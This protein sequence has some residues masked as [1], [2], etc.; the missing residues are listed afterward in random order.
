MR[1]LRLRVRNYRG[2]ADREIV[3]A[4]SGVTV[5]AGPNEIGKSSLAEAIDL[6]FDELDT[7][8]RQSVRDVKPADRDA[9]TEIEIDV[10]TGPYAFTYSKRFHRRHAT[11]LR[12]TRPR[13]EAWTGRDAHRR[14]REILDETIDT[15][16]WRA[17]RVQQGEGLAQ[18][19]WLGHGALAAALDRAAGGA[20]GAHAQTLFEAAEA[21]CARYF[22]RSGRERQELSTALREAARA[23]HAEHEA[24]E[25]LARL[26][27]DTSRAAEL[28]S[29]RARLEQADLA[30]ERALREAERAFEPIGTLREAAA[31]AA[32]RRDAAAADVRYALQALRQRSQ[33]VTAHAAS[34]ADLALLAGEI[35]SGEPALAGARAELDH[36]EGV[37]ARAREAFEAEA[38]T[39]ARLRAAAARQRAREEIDAL[40]QQRARLAAEREAVIAAEREVA[41]HR[42]DEAAVAEIREAERAVL[43][44]QARVES[45]GP[46]VRLSAHAELTGSLDGGRLALAEGESVEQRVAE[47]LLVSVPGL[48]DL[49]VVAGAGAAGRVKALDEARTRWRDRCAVCDVADHADA[50]RALSARR[51]AERRLAERRARVDELARGGSEADLTARIR[52]A[53]ATARASEAAASDDAEAP[54][55]ARHTGARLA[56]AD[57]RVRS[58][59]D[60]CAGAERR[61]DALLD[62]H[63]RLADHHRETLVRHELAD[64]AFR[65]L[66]ARLATA[67]AERADAELARQHELAA[68]RARSLE[69]RAA[70]ADRRLAEA[71]PA[72]AEAGLARARAA[73]ERSARDSSR[74]REELA[75]LSARLELRGESGL[76]QRV[77]EAG[78][79]ADARES[80][81]AGLARRARAARL[82]FDTLREEREIAREGYALPLATR[83][84]EF[85]RPV[86]GAGFAVEL[87]DSLRIARRIQDGLSLPFD[88]LSA[89]A[90]EQLALIS[91]LAVA[92]LVADAGGA[93]VILDDALGHSDP[94]RLA[95]LGRALSEA[96]ERVQILVLTCTPERFRDVAG[97]HVVALA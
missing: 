7:T 24:R 62:R 49:T 85:G 14:A 84:Q 41:L 63:R 55:A 72:Q 46:L 32:A 31:A 45:E 88:Q 82:L 87:D 4:P 93:P 70:E 67:R 19:S 11:A 9:D 81:A 22:T 8:T 42:I 97:A 27:D 25:E 2:I 92:S 40:A 96:G 73:R 76:Y 65:D 80:E 66:E 57:A 50:L 86:F 39:E 54:D 29:A 58:A 90:R 77:E 5:I 21:E 59:R 51:D 3:P 6:L 79:E 35:E 26:A 89:G 74:L 60:A 37:L 53:E 10:E 43:R 28:R 69:A 17:L 44:A 47:S 15:G 1:I 33:L 16:L 68:E 64:H 36:A 12:V 38:G 20:E 78:A 18:A 91:R 13:V 56:D 83:I 23:R 30:C 95:R 75:H 61:R 34:E 52:D 94:E 71:A 48:F